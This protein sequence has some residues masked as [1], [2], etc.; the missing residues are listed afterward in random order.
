M[1]ADYVVV[2]SGLTGAVIARALKDAGRDVVVVEARGHAGGN[3][4]DHVHEPTGIRVHTYGPHYFRTSSPR[5]WAWVNRF[6]EFYPYHAEVR[7]LVGDQLEAWPVTAE[8]VARECG[9]NWRPSFTG[10]PA[11]FEEA[12]LAMMPREI[13]ERFVRGYTEKQWGVPATSLSASLARRFDVRAGDDRRLMQHE[14]Q[15]I[16]VGGYTEFMWAVLRGIPLALGE[17]YLRARSRWRA[18]KLLVYTGSIDALFDY[19]LGRLPYRGQLRRAVHVRQRG[20]PGD[21]GGEYAQEVG[22]VNYPSPAVPEIRSLEWKHMLTPGELARLRPRAG[23]VL[24]YEVPYTPDSGGS[25]E[26]P[27]PSDSSSALASAYLALAER[28]PDTLVCGRLGEYR[29]LDMDQAIA[30]ALVLAERI[31]A[32]S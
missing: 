23:T 4:H 7:T 20:V 24:T 13:Y 19:S 18:R 14:Y 17:D 22:Q 12:S 3:V 8:Y 16:P 10:E 9:M 2:G 25:L 15:G 11:N 21:L 29:Y 32:G 28:L 1:R 27:F 30:R 5:I 26:Y 31:L 6:A